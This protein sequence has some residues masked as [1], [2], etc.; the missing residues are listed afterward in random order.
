[1]SQVVESEVVQRSRRY[2]LLPRPPGEERTPIG[3]RKEKVGV[4]ATYLP[5][6]PF[7]FASFEYWGAA[8]SR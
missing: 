6:V 2:G 3:T 4:E 7:K 8:R 5:D 1:M